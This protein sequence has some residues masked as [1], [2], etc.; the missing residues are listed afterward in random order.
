MMAAVVNPDKGLRLEL[1]SLRDSTCAR[2]YRIRRMIDMDPSYQRQGGIWTL[3]NRQ[4]F[5]DSLLNGFD[6]PKLYLHRS[7]KLDGHKYAV[8]DGKQRLEAIFGFFNNEYPLAEEFE[9]INQDQLDVVEVD[10]AELG[11]L[12]GLYYSDLQYRFPDLAKS[13][14]ARTLDVV[15]I[16]TEDEEAIEELFS[17]LNEAAPLNAAEK[18]NALGGPMPEA[19]KELAA[20]PFFSETLPFGNNRYRHYDL[21]AK[22]ILWALPLREGSTPDPSRIRDSKRATLDALFLQARSGDPAEGKI[23]EA[24]GR[25]KAALHYMH[26]QFEPD[27]RLL[28]SVGTVAVVFLATLRYVQD[29]TQPLIRRADLSEFEQARRD[30]DFIGDESSIK[31]V[32]ALLEY[33]RLSQ[34]PND[35]SALATRLEILLAFVALSAEDRSDVRKVLTALGTAYGEDF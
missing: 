24:M 7:S 13:L 23:A 17:R 16:D 26:E 8:V 33:N 14:D 1:A 31:G 15:V 19:V 22:C 11:Q 9:I 18:R 10:H 30:P 2:I 6:V 28:S 25:A 21:A 29:D 3:K 35:G 27:D 4:L 12:G 32:R 34:S 20:E 5:V